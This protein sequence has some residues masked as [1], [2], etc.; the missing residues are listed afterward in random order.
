[1]PEAYTGLEVIAFIA[2]PGVARRILEH[3]ALDATGPPLSP[4]RRAEESFDPMPRADA[5]DPVYEA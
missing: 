5:G 3:L 1:M 4:A 2:D